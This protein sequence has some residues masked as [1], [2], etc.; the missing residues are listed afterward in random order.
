MRMN[1][2]FASV[3]AIVCFVIAFLSGCSI[4]EGT[5]NPS[6]NVSVSRPDRW[7]VVC[8]D[9]AN[10]HGE[11]IQDVL[12]YFKQTAFARG[13]C[14]SMRALDD[15]STVCGLGTHFEF[16]HDDWYRE[17][18][19]GPRYLTGGDPF[20][21]GDEFTHAC[22]EGFEL[23]SSVLNQDARLPPLERVRRGFEVLMYARWRAS[24]RRASEPGSR[25]HVIGERERCIRITLMSGSDF[26]HR[27]GL[28]IDHC[29]TLSELPEFHVDFYRST[30]FEED[31]QMTGL[32]MGEN[33]VGTPKLYVIAD[34]FL[35][36][37]RLG[38]MGAVLRP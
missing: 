11:A 13:Y 31:E 23:R 3:C 38:Q 17:R 15:L 19:S 35:T 10:R 36:T 25:F 7:P 6:A 29:N 4:K 8:R 12:D 30:A 24:M 2:G 14:P 26:R 1:R 32:W 22:R 27:D 33:P 20:I 28:S 34:E 37:G 9:L 18:E 5:K 16:P 21:D